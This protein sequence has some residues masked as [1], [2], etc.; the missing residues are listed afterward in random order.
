MKDIAE[1]DCTQL[2]YRLSYKE[3]SAKDLWTTFQEITQSYF[4]HAVY[5]I[6]WRT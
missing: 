2:H 6:I 1:K 4:A 5:N 3:N